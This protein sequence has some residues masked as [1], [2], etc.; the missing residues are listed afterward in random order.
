MSATVMQW[1]L[2]Q[3]CGPSRGFCPECQNSFTIKSAGP[4]G[5]PQGSANIC[6][7]PG[8]VPPPVPCNRCKDRISPS[9][10]LIMLYFD[11][12]YPGIHSGGTWG[13]YLAEQVG[14]C[15][16]QVCVPNEFQVSLGLS[17]EVPDPSILESAHGLSVATCPTI[18]TQFGFATYRNWQN[19][20]TSED[21]CRQI[22][23]FNYHDPT[24][25]GAG[26]AIAY[27]IFYDE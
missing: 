2:T 7:A 20:L 21:G 22:L 1:S 18:G 19:V 14:S 10:Y 24:S 5:C 16:Y 8:W 4:Y 12:S 6:L 23:Y 17:S 9:A 26:T 27:P 13:P 15:G 25:L 3:Q 11:G